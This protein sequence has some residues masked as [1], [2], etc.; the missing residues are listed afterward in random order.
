MVFGAQHI[1]GPVYL[2]I[3]LKSFYASVECVDMGLDPFK[4]NL[5][6]ADTSRS[7]RTICLAIS[8]ALKA[9]G[10]TGRPR[11]VESPKSIPFIAAPPRMRR[12]MEVSARIHR[13]Y[14]RYAAPS[15]I[16]VYSIDECFIDAAPY[17]RLYRISPLELARRMM[18]A[19]FAE[20]GICA[21]AGIGTN[22]VLAKVALD[23][24]AKN[25][26]TRMGELDEL[27]FRKRLWDHRPITDFWG[28]GPGTARRLARYGVHDMR[29]IRQ[30]RP[31]T[32]FR[33]FGKNARYLMDHALGLE[34]CTI[35]DIK[36][37]RPRAHSLSVGQ[38]LP[39]P[40]AFDEARLVFAEMVEQLSMDLVAN[41]AGHRLPVV[42]GVLRPG[43]AG[44]VPLR[45]PAV[46]RLLRPAAPEAHRG[47]GAAAHPHRQ[48]PDRTSV[49]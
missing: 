40:Y 12:Y 22:L 41:G 48:R 14:L 1:D 35:A 21:T 19:V 28:I 9:L 38:V 49:G 29:G 31:E 44:K 3:D 23:I 33:E 15:D 10:V 17:L 34:P 5:V 13:I 26:P 47:H 46:H 25:S 27:A 6:V 42:L 18:D 43:L 37:Y 8:P 24:L 32:L 11:L 36:A 39:R 7:D 20:T 16:H 2:C 45:R 30:M 4:V